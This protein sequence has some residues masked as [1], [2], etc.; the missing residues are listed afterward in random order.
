M[1]SPLDRRLAR[2]SFATANL[3]ASALV[4]VGVFRGLPARWW[5]VD[6]GAGV[7]GAVLL[8]S[9]AGLFTRARWAERATRLASFIVLALGL[10]LVTTLALTASWLWGVYG[11]LGRGG[12]MLLVLVAALALPYL[13]ALPALQL[14]WIGAPRGRG[15]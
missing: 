15:R 6:A 7:A 9:A 11:P 4:L 5:V 3:V 12:A 8:V 2:L 13:V 14:L 10:A 1:T